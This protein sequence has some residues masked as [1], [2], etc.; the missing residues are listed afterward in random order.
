MSRWNRSVWIHEEP[1]IL[2][3]QPFKGIHADE[4]FRPFVS[5]KW[6]LS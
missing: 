2:L 6:R 1:I 3:K 5:D 4:F